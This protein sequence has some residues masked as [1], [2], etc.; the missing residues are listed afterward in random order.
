MEFVPCSLCYATT[1]SQNIGI[2]YANRSAV[3]L[4]TGY[5]HLALENIKLARENNYPIDKTTKLDERK[6]L[7]LEKLKNGTDKEDHLKKYEDAW[8]KMMDAKLP[9]NPKYPF[10]IADCLSLETSKKYGKHLRCNADVPVGT[11]LAIEEPLIKVS[12]HDSRYKN[13][14]NCLQRSHLNLFPCTSCVSAMYCSEKCRE[15]SFQN[16]HRFVCGVVDFL[17]NCAPNRGTLFLKMFCVGLNLFGGPKNFAEALTNGSNSTAWDMDVQGL[18]E[19]EVKKK[20]WLALYSLQDRDFEDNSPDNRFHFEYFASFVASVLN[21]SNLKDILKSEDEKALFRKFCLN[22]WKT[23]VRYF[24]EFPEG[25]STTDRISVGGVRYIICAF[26][27]HSC[28]RNVYM[29]DRNS[30]THIV[31]IRPIKKGDILTAA[32]G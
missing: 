7:C 4:K 26:F 3:Y 5:Y 6:K 31:A 11:I 21:F 32:F 29:A 20:L 14:D 8:T 12:Q 18:D 27:K 30:K 10:Y 23:S 1:G 19:L 22:Q 15:E 16:H 13:C 2:A 28:V 24:H 25:Y 17:D 9:A